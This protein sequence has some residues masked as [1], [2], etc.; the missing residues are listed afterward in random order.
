[1]KTTFHS[2]SVPLLGVSPKVG[3]GCT[4]H[5]GLKKPVCLELTTFTR[6]Q[7]RLSDYL[8]ISAENLL[9]SFSV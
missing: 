5:R 4:P 2:L 3:W 1:M 6:H 9:F 8:Q 7:Q